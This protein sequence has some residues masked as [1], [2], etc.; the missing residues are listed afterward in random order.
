M[1]EYKLKKSELSIFKSITRG[2]EK[3][4]DISDDT[5]IS[6]SRSSQLLNNLKEKEFIYYERKGM[7]KIANV[8]NTKHA[9]L[10]K[11]LIHTELSIKEILSDSKLDI[12]FSIL[13]GPKSL[14]RISLETGLAHETLR[15]YIREMKYLT[16]VFETD[17]KEISLTVHKTLKDFL[18]EYLNYVNRITAS[19]INKDSM[20]LWE[21]GRETI[22]R[23]P[24]PM[25]D[26]KAKVTGI[27]AMSQYGIDIISNYAYYYYSPFGGELKP[28]DIAIH[29]ILAGKERRNITYALLFLKKGGFDETYLRE[30]GSHYA[31]ENIIKDLIYFLDDKLVEN[32]LFPSRKEFNILCEEYGVN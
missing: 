30:K 31:I 6:L 19:D 28:D 2:K 27:T 20:L 23:I 5:G 22:F 16:S 12:L 13:G 8:S 9:S 4:V 24:L 18:A 14:E 21:Q 25:G 26:V 1:I 11:S 3:L 17:E 32:P 10:L 7:K 29:T 15:K